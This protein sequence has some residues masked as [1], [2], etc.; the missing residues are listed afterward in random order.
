MCKSGIFC[1]LRIM[2]LGEVVVGMLDW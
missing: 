2:W 1:L